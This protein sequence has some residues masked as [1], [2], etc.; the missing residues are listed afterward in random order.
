MSRRIFS[1]I[2]AGL[3]VTQQYAVAADA[4]VISFDEAVRIG[5]ERNTLLRQ[6]EIASA[7][8]AV[9]VDQARNRFKPNLS[10]TSRVGQ[11]FG[12]NFNQDEGQ[13]INTSNTTGT[14]GLSS[15]LTVFDGFANTAGLKSAR[16][17]ERAGQQD[18]G[19][20]RETV[21]FTVASNFL[22]LVQAQEELRVRRESLAAQDALEQQISSYV[23]AG[24]RTIADLY[25]QQAAVASARFAVVEAERAAQ[26]A[27][28]NLIATL[29]L[30]PAGAYQFD[31]VPY[32]AVAASQDIPNLEAML[33]SAYSQRDDLSAEQVRVEAADQDVR[34]AKSSRWPVV[35]LSTSYSSSYTSAS[36]FDFQEQLD[37]RRGGSVNLNFTLP[38][39]DRG[40]TRVAIRRAELEADSARLALE[41]TRHNVGV[42]VRT[43]Y[44]DFRAAREQLTSADAQLKAA[45]L[46]LDA[47]QQRYQAGAATLVELSQARATQV[48]AA[49][50]LVSAKSNLLFQRTLVNYYLGELDAESAKTP[51]GS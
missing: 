48:Q 28:T 38:L 23:D 14:L 22:G 50:S 49:S 45:E 19:R 20:A 39:F 40:D 37:Q 9:A 32:D 25:Q 18:L 3:L 31:P 44:Q 42:E 1:T 27:E 35:S 16:L 46:A 34:I 24:A 43:A 5:L 17:S 2:L 13:I 41:A 29:Q 26:L 6:A 36:D 47:A 8:D 10:L 30:D 21:I 11:S 51:Q 4:R 12:R 15:S 33:A 7:V